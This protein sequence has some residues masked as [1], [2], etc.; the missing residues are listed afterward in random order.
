[1]DLKTYVSDYLVKFGGSDPVIVDFVIA[2]ASGAKSAD[3][4]YQKLGSSLTGEE[5]EIRQFT[6][7]LFKKTGY[8]PEK[9]NGTTTATSKAPSKQRYAM[10]AMDEEDVDLA[11]SAPP[12]QS[13]GKSSA[14]GSSKSKKSRK[15]EKVVRKRKSDEDD[16]RSQSEDSV[17][18]EEISTR[19]KRRRLHYSP[20]PVRSRSG[21]PNDSELERNRKE[22]DE[23]NR[24]IKARDA[25]RAETRSKEDMDDIRQASRYSYLR[26]REE[27]QLYLL[28]KRVQQQ[29]EER[30]VD[31]SLTQKEL[32]EFDED[33]KRLEVIEDRLAAREKAEDKSGFYFQDF[34]NIDKQ[35]TLS[36]RVQGRGERELN[37]VQLWE[38]EQTRRAQATAA[39]RSQRTNA[40][41]YEYVWDDSQKLNF[42]SAGKIPGTMDL[43][44]RQ[45][46]EQLQAALKKDATLQEK[47]K[48]LPMYAMRGELVS[49]L[50]EH[51]NMIISSATGS[52]KTTQIPQY[53]LEENLNNGL[54]IGVTQPRRVAAM[55]VAARVAEERGTRLGQEVGYS[56]RFEHKVS[57]KTKIK[58]MTDGMLLRE[59]V[60]NPTLDAYGVIMLDEAHERTLDTDILLAFL[61]DLSRARPD[62]KVII[63]S[64]TLNAAK[65]A[66]FLDQCPIFHVPGRSY[67]IDK[68][69]AQQPE[70]NYLQAAV[71][72]VFQIHISQP[73]DGDILVFLTG[74]EDIDLGV[75]QIEDTMKKL[76]NRVR[77]LIVAPIYSALPS[78]M[79]AK[80]FEP[81][82][83]GSRKVV[84]AT[85][86]AETSLTIDGIIYVIDAGLA[87]EN[88]FNPS[89]GTSSLQ[90]T[91]ISRA[92]AEQRAGRAGRTQ[93]GKCFRLYTKHNYYTELQEEATPEIQR[94]DMTSTVL[95][96]MTIGITDLYSFDFLDAPSPD[97]LMKAMELLYMIGALN[98]SG[99]VTRLGRQM[100]EVP[101]DVR[102]SAAIIA[103]GKYGCVQEVLTVVAL[104][105]E[106][107]NLWFR[108]KEQKVHADAARA[109]FS[110]DGGDHMSL[111]RVYNAW[112][113]TDYSMTWCR[114]NFIQYR[115][116]Q[117]ARLIREQLENLCARIEIPADSST[118]PND[119]V[120]V[121]KALLSGYFSNSATLSRDGQHY[122]IRRNNMSVRIHP[123][124]VLIAQADA[125]KRPRVVMFHELVVTSGEWMRGVAPIE[126]DWLLEVAPHFYKAAEVEK[127]ERHKK[128]VPKAVGLE[129]SVKQKF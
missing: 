115:S 19:K 98:S 7:G 88:V 76:G 70:A 104:L 22:L 90:T 103:A 48:E 100:V 49:A 11:R 60:T 113:D 117:R 92:A 125:T 73:T 10:V 106:S 43:Q 87:K 65:F 105:E 68:L 40:K 57:E 44:R 121:L 23:L 112:V 110:G 61:K 129:A 15:Q 71:T 78:D 4:L 99:Q 6:D 67:P 46:E 39:L 86:I 55:S 82:P 35:E 77:P 21:T 69:F 25:E 114:E 53:I 128:K 111:L 126:G 116:L 97:A 93:P 107:A 50:R 16:W 83:P 108:P 3:E 24:K 5:R 96:L 52:G 89:T 17:P 63:S 37:D 33:K 74:Q 94:S 1:M 13:N 18:E 51:Q 56:V 20:S 30:Q 59:L 85:N 72:T 58:F 34:K 64:A 42:E 127:M 101:S 62:L 102:L 118:G 95:F 38:E 123:S 91:P 27:E 124:S 41:D 66:E 80:I 2:Q 47:R 9:K 120:P 36:R 75:E 109:R 14:H 28:R 26:K 81:T 54:M 79:Q 122:T 119:H 12:V 84:L 8:K 31:P 45:F 29:E 32:D